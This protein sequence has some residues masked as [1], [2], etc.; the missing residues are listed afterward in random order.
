[1][2]LEIRNHGRTLALL[3]LVAVLAF[4]AALGIAGGAGA[5]PS[6]SSTGGQAPAFVP[7]QSEGEER[8]APRDGRDC[9]EG[10][11]GQGSGASG[12]QGTATPEV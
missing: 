4:A 5:T 7:V 11:R 9:P 10:E 8:P 1:M 3:A 6:S 2:K 12:A